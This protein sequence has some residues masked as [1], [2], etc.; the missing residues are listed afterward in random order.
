MYPKLSPF[1]GYR[2][3]ALGKL[4]HLGLEQL[5]EVTVAPGNIYTRQTGRFPV[6]SIKGKKYVFV[7]YCYE[8]NSI[9]TESLKYITGK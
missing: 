7:L 1:N 4:S 8:Y 9:I 6:T 2:W 5:I 3:C